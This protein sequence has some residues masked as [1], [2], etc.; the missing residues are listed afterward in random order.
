MAN[1]YF[2]ATGVLML[3]RVTPVITALFGAFNLDE[4]YP[5]D[6]RA[7]IAR[8]SESDDAQWA[9]VLDA[10]ADLAAKLDLTVQDNDERAAIEAVLWTLAAHFS[11]DQN[12]PLAQ[13]IEHHSFEDNAD[14]DALFLMA[15]CFDDG[16]HLAAIL[17]EGCWH[18][19]KPR[20][21]EFGGEGFFLSREVRLFRSSSDAIRL[22]DGIRNAIQA[23]ETKQAASLI[24]QEVLE[25]LSGVSDARIQA[26]LHRQVAE[27]LLASQ[28][29][30][31]IA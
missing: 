29:S 26:R 12:E 28:P 30:G 9:T 25:L 19:S 23:D 21:F 13:L 11:A 2:D 22:G 10:L 7:Y 4:T 16:H 15:S 20:L 1:N 8:I 3:D 5:G 6:G 14:L 27:C 24:L 17:L 31:D 18:C